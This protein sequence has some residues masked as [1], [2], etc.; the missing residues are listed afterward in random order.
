MLKFNDKVIIKSGFFER[1]EG[2]LKGFDKYSLKY[3]VYIKSGPAEFFFEK[4]IKKIK[5]TKKRKSKK[6]G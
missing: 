2:V 3:E 4:E 6:R 1:A 5:D